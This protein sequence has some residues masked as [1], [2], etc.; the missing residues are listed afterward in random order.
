MRPDHSPPGWAPFPGIGPAEKATGLARELLV[1]AGYLLLGV[2]ADWVIFSEGQLS[3]KLRGRIFSLLFGWGKGVGVGR[4]VSFQNIRSI[5]VGPYT[6]I[7]RES[8]IMGP[9]T[10]G[11]HC[12]VGERNVIFP[13]TTIE[14]HVALG[15][16]VYILTMWHPIGA[17]MKRAGPGASRPIHVGRG[18][19]I[20]AGAMILAGCRVGEGAVVAGGAKVTRSVPPN[21][22]VAGNPAQIVRRLIQSA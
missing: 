19:C 13:M 4:F 1:G 17:P 21:V 5:R 11:E 18:A 6:R 20:N 22:V 14:D 8:R 16:L 3:N 2:L 15:P 10:I 7:Q 12:W 9:V